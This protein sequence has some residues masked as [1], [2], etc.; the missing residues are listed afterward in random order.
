[1]VGDGM[2]GACYTDAGADAVC[3]LYTGRKA[4][5]EDWERGRPGE[6]G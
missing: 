6:C 5:G 1:M 2:A 4:Q 3:W